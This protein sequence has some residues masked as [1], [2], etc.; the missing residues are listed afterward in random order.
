MVARAKKPRS[1][2]S[3]AGVHA[4]TLLVLAAVALMAA[5]T[6]AS[7]AHGGHP[8]ARRFG[9]E[10]RLNKG[11]YDSHRYHVS[12]TGCT[13]KTSEEDKFNFNALYILQLPAGKAAPTIDLV[14]LDPANWAWSYLVE[15][16]G[17]GGEAESEGPESCEATEGFGVEPPPGDG[18][19]ATLRKGSLQLD[20]QATSG[21]VIEEAHGS[22]R[23]EGKLGYS[24][25]DPAGALFMPQML[26]TR[27]T[28]PLTA[29]TKP[30]KRR[31]GAKPK[32]N[33]WTQS[34]IHLALAA[35]PPL[36]CSPEAAGDTCD[37]H[38]SWEG[39]VRVFA[40]K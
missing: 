5:A 29:L 19:A 10:F 14:D 38:V 25:F 3:R 20:L 8:H 27:V 31:R 23:C 39:A 11:E 35:R 40:M 17:C 21:I 2:S 32:P 37:Q 18:P 34:G 30:P 22:S 24:L 1:T 16:S 33:L 36:D 13:S 12:D 4:V 9:V 26:G 7:G 28:V 15:E 6:P